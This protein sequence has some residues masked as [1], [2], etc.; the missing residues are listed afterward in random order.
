M[1]KTETTIIDKNGN[2][3]VEVIEEIDDGK[4]N[5]S[6]KT[7]QIAGNADGLNRSDKYSSK[8]YIK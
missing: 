4:G 6:L 2:K 8:K 7:K 5:I 1:T 3:K